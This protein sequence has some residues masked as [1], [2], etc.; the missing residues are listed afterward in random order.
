VIS[1]G[2]AQPRIGCSCAWERFHLDQSLRLCPSDLVKY[3]SE[4]PIDLTQKRRKGR[5]EKDSA[6]SISLGAWNL[7]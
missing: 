3:A 4:K 2:P 6:G 1:I 7:G 5:L